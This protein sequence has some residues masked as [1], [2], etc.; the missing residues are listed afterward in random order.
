[1]ISQYLEFTQMMYNQQHPTFCTKTHGLIISWY[2]I[3]F[4]FVSGDS[5][6][7]DNSILTP[8]Y[9]SNIDE[10]KKEFGR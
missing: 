5:D 2:K 4:F 1:M 10:K 9:I 6:L 3:S 7:S 8:M